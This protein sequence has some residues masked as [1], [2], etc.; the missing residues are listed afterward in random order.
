MAAGRGRGGQHCKKKSLTWRSD[1]FLFSTQHSLPS[2]HSSAADSIQAD[3]LDTDF[4]ALIYPY[5]G[6]DVRGI[7]QPFACILFAAEEME[8]RQR[9]LGE[10]EQHVGSLG[11]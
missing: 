7:P 2:L 6:R 10:E 8:I 11:K 3:G 5:K 1:V 9:T 4:T